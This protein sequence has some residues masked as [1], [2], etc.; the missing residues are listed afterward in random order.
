MVSVVPITK[1]GVL[2]RVLWDCGWLATGFEPNGPERKR[3][4][5]T[6]YHYSACSAQSLYA[7]WYAACSTV[8]GDRAQTESGSQGRV[9]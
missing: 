9:H 2:L 6:C 8:S 3:I 7:E 1:Y 5:P 4:Q